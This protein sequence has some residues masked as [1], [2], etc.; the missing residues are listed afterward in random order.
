MAA[1]LPRYMYTYTDTDTDTYTY[2]DTDTYTYPCTYETKLLALIFIRLFIRITPI[3]SFFPT[4]HVL[5][6]LKYVSS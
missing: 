2:T 4:V 1:Y 5:F 6:L 3:G